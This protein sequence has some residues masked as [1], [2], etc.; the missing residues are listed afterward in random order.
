MNIVPVSVESELYSRFCTLRCFIINVINR[1]LQKV[2]DQSS[3]VDR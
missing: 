1:F 2:N 3:I